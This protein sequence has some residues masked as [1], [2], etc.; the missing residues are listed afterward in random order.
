MATPPPSDDATVPGTALNRID[1]KN[2]L[3]G[4]PFPSCGGEDSDAFQSEAHGLFRHERQRNMR[5]VIRS[6]QSRFTCGQT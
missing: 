6:E 2:V 4:L 3:N 1:K 5:L